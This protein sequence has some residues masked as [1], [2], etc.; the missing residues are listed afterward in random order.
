MTYATPGPYSGFYHSDSSSYYRA[1]VLYSSSSTIALFASQWSDALHGATTRTVT[2]TNDISGLSVGS[3]VN[4]HPVQH[5][6]YWTMWG[7]RAATGYRTPFFPSTP[8][9]L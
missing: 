3:V 2:D 9:S 5:G 8:A 4:A 1:G 6:Y 7:R